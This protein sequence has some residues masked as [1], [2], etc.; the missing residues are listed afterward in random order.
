MVS[1]RATPDPARVAD[2]LVAEA[3]RQQNPTAFFAIG[4]SM[5]E[6]EGRRLRQV[7]AGA[8]PDREA[9][10]LDNTAWQH[11]QLRNYADSA[12]ELAFVRAFKQAAVGE[13]GDLDDH[14]DAAL[15]GYRAG[16]RYA[17]MAALDEDE[18]VRPRITPEDEAEAR[19]FAR[20]GVW[21]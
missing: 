10:A 14:S 19:H 6:A 11:A 2:D 5:C 18:P 4:V 13:P 8:D 1:R 21:L 3:V 16:Q 15:D 12:D 9:I 7:A 20:H 17:R